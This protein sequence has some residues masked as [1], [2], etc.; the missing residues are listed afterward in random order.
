MTIL[1]AP[2][3]HVPTLPSLSEV[4][5]EAEL[6]APPVTSCWLAACRWPRHIFTLQ[7]VARCV[8]H[9]AGQWVLAHGMQGALAWSGWMQIDVSIYRH[10]I[11]W[12]IQSKMINGPPMLN[13]PD[14]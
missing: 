3:Q 14:L 13:G 7:V 1:S 8:R 11:L 10:I 5:I 12:Y 6:A 4:S 2:V 9:A